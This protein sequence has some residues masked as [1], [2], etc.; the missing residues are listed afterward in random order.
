MVNSESVGEHQADLMQAEWRTA[1]AH[2]PNGDLR[3]SSGLTFNVVHDE[4]GKEE[5]HID[6]ASLEVWQT[7]EIQGGL[8]LLNIPI[9]RARLLWE[10]QQ[11]LAGRGH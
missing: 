10:A 8:G 4:T 9:R 11:V 7:F 1:W 6:L 3:H 5:L 2:L